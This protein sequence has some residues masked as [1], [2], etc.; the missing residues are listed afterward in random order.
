MSSRELANVPSRTVFKRVIVVVNPATRRNP[1]RIAEIVAHA[2]PAGTG[3]EIRQTVAGVAV[4]ELLSPG[5]LDV[6]AVIA[7]G[8]DGTV[9]AVATALGDSGVPLGIIPVGSTNVI[10]REQGIPH[11]AVIAARLIFGAHT[12]RRMDAGICGDRRFLHMAGAGIDS[13]L[14]LATDPAAKRKRGW[15]AYLGPALRSLRTAPSRFTI[16]T[17]DIVVEVVSPLVLV[18]NGTSILKPF[19][20]TFRTIRP[21]DGLLD[22]LVF[23]AIRP[24]PIASALGRFATRSLDRSSYVTRIPTRTARISADPSLPV[25]LDGDVVTQTPAEFSVAPGALRM[26]VPRS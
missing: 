1:D 21:D 25:E 20:P 14:F 9:A 24:L 18:A 5:M 26:I 16:E 13:R 23:T 17:D 8:G 15:I 6:D 4:Q 19:F 12:Y 7:A 10:A 2:A 3:V 11:N 22:V